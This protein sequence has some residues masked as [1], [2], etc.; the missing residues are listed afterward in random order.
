M[1]CYVGRRPFRDPR[2]PCATARLATGFC[3]PKAS[4]WKPKPAA[5]QEALQAL[6]DTI[7]ALG[8]VFEDD[9]G[10]VCPVSVFGGAY[11]KAC[12]TLGLE[13]LKGKD[14]R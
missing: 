4:K 2:I 11:L 6:V 5:M 12:E 8:G 9:H 14:P 7:N 1:M 13:P 10:R 3:G